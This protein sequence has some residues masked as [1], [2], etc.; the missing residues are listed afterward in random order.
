MMKADHW[1]ELSDHSEVLSP[2]LLVYP[3]RVMYNAE[4]MVKIAKGPERLRPHIKTHKMGD[5]IKLQK[6][7]GINKFKCATLAEA[8]LLA[9]N[10]ASDVLL[11]MQPVA[12]QLERYLELSKQYPDIK[13]STL[14]DNE[15]SLT[16]FRDAAS[17]QSTM[18]DIW[19]DLN[20]GM[21]RTGIK[22]G[23]EAAALYKQADH[24]PLLNVKGLH[25]YDGH[26]HNSDYSER[27]EICNK[28]YAPIQE[29]KINLELLGHKPPLI[30]A[31]GTPTFPVHEKRKD[32]ELSPGTPLLWDEGYGHQYKDLNFVPAA[33][34]LTRIISKPEKNLLCF[35]LGHK[36]VASEMPLPRVKFLGNH[37]FEQISQSEEHLVVRCNN[38]DQYSI[39]HTCYAVPIHICPTVAKYGKALTVEGQKVTGFWEVSARDHD[40]N[41]H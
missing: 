33:V 13:F 29:L 21:N 36:S 4:L 35:D 6:Q 15:K 22:P 39:G 24:E 19:L 5:I 2:A 27:T 20:N 23:K 8:K 32:V 12:V 38:S 25:V 7:L 28:A 3:K 16:A 30:I 9:E 1:Y 31:G 34:L 26:I 11:A 14:F 40:L 41:L 17:R 37:Q 18:L 10:G